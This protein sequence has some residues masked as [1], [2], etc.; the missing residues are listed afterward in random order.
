MKKQELTAFTETLETRIKNLSKMIEDLRML[1]I[2]P[3]IKRSIE[4]T[5][6]IK[7]LYEIELEQIK[8]L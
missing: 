3:I 2:S 1:P 4:F 8:S 5:Q 6:R 7:A